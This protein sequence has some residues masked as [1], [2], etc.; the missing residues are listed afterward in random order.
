[1]SQDK[2][3]LILISGL[4]GSGKSTCGRWISN[5][6]KIPYIDYD[7]AIQSFMTEIYTRHYQEKP[8][9][10]FCAIWRGC[11]YKTFWGMIAEN[12]RAG[13]SV[14]ASAP[15]SREVQQRDFFSLIKREYGIG[16][17]VLSIILEVSEKVLYSRIL[18][19]NEERDAEKLRDWEEYYRKQQKEIRW[20][21]DNQI[22]FQADEDYRADRRI[23]SFLNKG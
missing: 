19:R 5:N 1:M 23:E 21:P 2:A 12:L 3:K 16:F 13:I 22:V 11:C 20:N 18:E 15:L 14:T 8:Y 7:T 6:Y 9:D 17:E 4:P 10:E